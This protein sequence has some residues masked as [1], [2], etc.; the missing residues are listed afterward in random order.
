LCIFSDWF[1]NYRRKKE[2]KMYRG[3]LIC[4]NAGKPK[5]IDDKTIFEMA[6]EPFATGVEK[7][8]N[9]GASLVGGC[10]GTTPEHIQALADM[11]NRKK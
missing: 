3:P 7:C 6:P 9:A 1:K 10:C 2:A 5:L 11:L 8:L 4:L